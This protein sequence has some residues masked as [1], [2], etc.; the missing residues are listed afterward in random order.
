[1]IVPASD[2]KGTSLKIQ[3]TRA[4]GNENIWRQ[5]AKFGQA[6]SSVTSKEAVD[7]LKKSIARKEHDLTPA[8]RKEL[9]LALDAIETPGQITAQVIKSFRQQYG[10]WTKNLGFQAIWVVGPNEAL[11]FRL[12]ETDL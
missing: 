6:N 5:I 8:Q 10:T 9:I 1:M 2:A 12:D 4:A 7:E 11:T 3:I